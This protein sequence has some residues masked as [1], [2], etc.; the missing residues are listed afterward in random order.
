MKER[1]TPRAKVKIWLKVS[2]LQNKKTQTKP[3]DTRMNQ[4]K[5]NIG[6]NMVYIGAEYDEQFVTRKEKKLTNEI[7][8]KAF[9]K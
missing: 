6:G 8:I 3:T 7:L 9:T 1:K 5:L 4:K 2:V